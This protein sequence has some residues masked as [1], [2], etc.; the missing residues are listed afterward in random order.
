MNG[1]V[2]LLVVG[3]SAALGMASLENNI[4]TNAQQ[5]GVAEE[6]IDSQIDASL[7]LGIQRTGPDFEIDYKDLIVSCEFTNEGPDTI[8][9]GSTI[10]CKLLDEQ[11]NVIAEGS[12]ILGS[13]LGVGESET[14]IIDFVEFTNANNVE[15]V[16]EILFVVQG[17]TP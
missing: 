11:G 13:D 5:L 10:Y 12:I 6:S 3:V 9:A 14:V 8:L 4:V 2:L 16:F 7:I 15:N 1:L 17:P